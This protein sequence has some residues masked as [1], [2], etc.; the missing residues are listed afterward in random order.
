MS[1]RAYVL[2]SQPLTF[3]LLSTV[4]VVFLPIVLLSLVIVID[5]LAVVGI[6]QGQKKTLSSYLLILLSNPIGSVYAL[7]RENRMQSPLKTASR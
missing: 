5:R 3:P 7:Y 6:I 4:L 2:E 1:S